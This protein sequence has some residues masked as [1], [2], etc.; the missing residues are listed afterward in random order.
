MVIQMVLFNVKLK[1]SGETDR[2]CSSHCEPIRARRRD[3]AAL[4]PFFR[5][6]LSHEDI[7]TVQLWRYVMDNDCRYHHVELETPTHPAPKSP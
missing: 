2:S 5:L 4:N 6:R 7:V 1:K 3:L